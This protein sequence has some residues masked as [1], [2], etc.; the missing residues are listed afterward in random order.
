MVRAAAAEEP[1]SS[2]GPRRLGEKAAPPLPCGGGRPGA[3]EVAHAERAARLDVLGI[4]GHRL[5]QP[6]ERVLVLAAV[7]ERESEHRTHVGIGV[8]GLRGFLEQVERLV[9]VAGIECFFGLAQQF[10]DCVVVG[11]ERFVR[12]HDCT[13]DPA[14]S[15]SQ[16]S[17]G[18]LS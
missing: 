14:C 4:R 9:D 13:V 7:V 16:P 2:A 15:L 12:S 3:E 5:L 6:L 18:I 10:V 17:Y 8:L 11:I 1:V